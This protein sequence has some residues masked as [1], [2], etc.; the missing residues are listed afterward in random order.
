MSDHKDPKDRSHLW[1]RPERVDEKPPAAPEFDYALE[2]PRFLHKH[3]EE[4]I[5]VKTPG[6]CDDALAE[7]WQVHLHAVEAVDEAPAKK[8]KGK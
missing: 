3:G 2:L 6:E 4:S 7:G 5:I 1:V 8:K